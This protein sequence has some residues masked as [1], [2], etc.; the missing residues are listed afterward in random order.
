MFYFLMIPIEINILGSQHHLRALMP[1]HPVAGGDI[2]QQPVIYV[3]V[4]GRKPGLYMYEWNVRL[5]VDRYHRAVWG[6]FRNQERAEAFCNYADPA[7]HGRAPF[8][9]DLRRSDT[10][11]PPQV[12]EYERQPTATA[13]PTAQLTPDDRDA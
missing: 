10:T 6:I 9:P 3:V 2:R 8:R 5:Q 12:N 11:T 1:P 13:A 7:Q 4:H